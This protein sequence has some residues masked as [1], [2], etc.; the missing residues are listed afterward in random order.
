MEVCHNEVWGVVCGDS[1]WGTN[2][3]RVLCKEVGLASSRNGG[4]HYYYSYQYLTCFS[5][6]RGVFRQKEHY[7]APVVLNDVQCRGTEASIT[8]CPGATYG[9]F[10]FCSDI[11]AAQCEGKIV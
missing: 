10:A 3:A 11:A 1:G 9:N 7:D 6:P 2:G 5:G 4:I 8:Q